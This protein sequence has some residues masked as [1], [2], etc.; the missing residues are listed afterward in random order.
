MSREPV[1]LHVCPHCGR[2]F[3]SPSVCAESGDETVPTPMVVPP[4][5]LGKLLEGEDCG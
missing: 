5:T 1:I 4:R 3:D 2:V